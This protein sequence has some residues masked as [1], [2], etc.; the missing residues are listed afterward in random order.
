MSADNAPAN[1]ASTYRSS[2]STTGRPRQVPPSALPPVPDLDTTPPTPP[3]EF[4]SFTNRNTTVGRLVPNN[5]SGMSTVWTLSRETIAFEW[6]VQDGDPSS[7]QGYGTRS[8]KFSTPHTEVP[9]YTIEPSSMITFTASISSVRAF[10][11]N[12]QNMAVRMRLSTYDFIKD[13]VGH[14]IQFGSTVDDYFFASC[15]WKN[16]ATGVITLMNPNGQAL[17][18]NARDALLN[19]NLTGMVTI[20]VR[21]V[22]K[23][24]STSAPYMKFEIVAFQAQSVGNYVV[25]NMSAM[26][27]E[28]TPLPSVVAMTAT[29]ELVAAL[30]GLN[31]S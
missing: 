27:V 19:R 28:G 5:R 16:F 3:L 26:H 1:R 20:S 8:I 29:N 22:Q 4:H 14:D 30:A 13:L 23:E 21:V 10:Q 15:V 6:T 25:P 2:A 17:T 24:N 18:F 12:T 7:F 9:G 11:A 31:I